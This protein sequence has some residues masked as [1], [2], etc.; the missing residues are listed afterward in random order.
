M[1]YENLEHPQLLSE[2]SFLSR[3]TGRRN[4]K[5]RIRNL[6]LGSCNVNPLGP[7]LECDWGFILITLDAFGMVTFNYFGQGVKCQ[8]AACKNK[9]PIVYRT[10]SL[11][12]R[13]QFSVH[14]FSTAK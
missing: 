8:M 10:V 12:D 2:C 5:S 4:L 1:K 3:G 14:E 6:I 9:D 11:G 7:S 13:F